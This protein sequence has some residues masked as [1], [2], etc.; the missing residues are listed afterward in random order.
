MVK[1]SV[2]Q[3][4]RTEDWQQQFGSMNKVILTKKNFDRLFIAGSLS[5]WNGMERIKKIRKDNKQAWKLIVEKDP[6]HVFYY[7]LLQKNGDIYLSYGYQVPGAEANSGLITT[8]ILWLFQ[9]APLNDFSLMVKTPGMETQIGPGWYP[10]GQFDFNYDALPSAVINKEGFLIFTVNDDIDTLIVGE[11][12]YTYTSST[13]KCEKETYTLTKNEEGNF[14]LDIRH[15]NSIK[16]EYA[17]YYVPYRA[18]ICGR[19]FIFKLS[20]TKRAHTFMCLFY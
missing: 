10:G 17:V 19:Q 7:V 9:L 11:D 16:D 5:D 4:N 14:V 20:T 6:N 8:S 1:D 3:A 15:R 2:L 12:Y 18:L 13:G